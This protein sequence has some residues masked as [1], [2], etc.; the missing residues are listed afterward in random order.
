MLLSLDY[1]GSTPFPL[2][3]TMGFHISSKR[4]ETRSGGILVQNGFCLQLPGLVLAVD[5]SQVVSSTN[6]ADMQI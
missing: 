5:I 6:K 3:R 1:L 2:P 4:E